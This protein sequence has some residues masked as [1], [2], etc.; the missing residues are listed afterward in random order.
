MS[1]ATV[2]RKTK[3]CNLFCNIAPNVMK[4]DVARFTIYVRT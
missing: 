2:K 4:S 3:T 1:K